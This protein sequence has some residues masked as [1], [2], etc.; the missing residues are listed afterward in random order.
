[1]LDFPRFH[2]T[3]IK[4]KRNLYAVNQRTTSNKRKIEFF[5]VVRTEKYFF[6]VEI[7][8]HHR[9]KRGQDFLFIVAVERTDTH[10]VTAVFRAKKCRRDTDYFS[11]FRKNS[12]FFVQILIAHPLFGKPC[13]L[14]LPKFTLNIVELRHRRMLRHRLNVEE[15]NFGTINTN[16]CGVHHI[17]LI[18]RQKYTN[19]SQFIMHNTQ[20]F[21]T[22]PHSLSIEH[23]ALSIAHCIVHCA[24]FYIFMLEF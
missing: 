5:S 1:M 7:L 6:R 12:R 21:P 11:K 22:L 18:F 4:R 16:N 14:F 8:V 3:R 19:N 2:A 10:F 15:Q 24:F 17:F 23:Y 9:H 13:R 20:L